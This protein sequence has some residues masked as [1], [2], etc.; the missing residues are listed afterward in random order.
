MDYSGSTRN[1]PGTLK[2]IGYKNG[3]DTSRRSLAIMNLITKRNIVLVIIAVTVLY[4]AF[5]GLVWWSMGQP[6][7]KFG[8]VMARMPGPA[9]F[10]LAPFE[11][12][13]VHARAG[14]LTPGDIAP[15]FTL[16][17]LDKSGTLQLSSLASAQPVVL[18]FGSYT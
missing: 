11:T 7:E 8:R 12:M 4:G 14:Y 10:L 16:T 18:I 6:P 2:S 13:W 5:L 3:Y 15:D 1:S 9:V 17:K